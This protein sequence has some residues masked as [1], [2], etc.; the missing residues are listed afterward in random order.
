MVTH[1]PNAAAFSDRVI[2][3]ADGK[4]AGVL[5]D[6]T[7]DRVLDRMKRLGG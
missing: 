6:P 4:V 7:T 2:F 5:T 1:D 3:M